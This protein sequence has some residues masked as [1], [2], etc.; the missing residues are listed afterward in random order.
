MTAIMSQGDPMTAALVSAQPNPPENPYNE[1]KRLYASMDR[2]AKKGLD[3]LAL[4][5][6]SKC[7][8]DHKKREKLL[9]LFLD[10]G[11]D[12][13]IMMKF[14]SR[15][16]QAGANTRTHLHTQTHAPVSTCTGTCTP[17]HNTHTHICK[18]SLSQTRTQTHTL[19]HARTDAH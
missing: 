19:T 4:A 3:P 13:G 10:N 9:K 7:K 14:Y 2:Q 5:E 16:E 11:K 6:Y 18:H 8:G 15:T 12:V 17:V 1:R